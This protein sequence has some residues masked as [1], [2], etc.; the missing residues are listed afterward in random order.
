LPKDEKTRK[1]EINRDDL[2]TNWLVRR[3][4]ESEVKIYRQEVLQITAK[5]DIVTFAMRRE[6]RMFL[7]NQTA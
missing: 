6:P 7:E 5:D 2:E 1:L 3:R 4:N